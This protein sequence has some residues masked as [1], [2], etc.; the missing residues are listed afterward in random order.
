VA[1]PSTT[2]V[3]TTSAFPCSTTGVITS[4]ATGC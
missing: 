4:S 2:S 1:A 3:T